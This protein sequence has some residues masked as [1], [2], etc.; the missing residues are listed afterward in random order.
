MTDAS[1]EEDRQAWGLKL[2]SG[3]SAVEFCEKR[4]VVGVGWHDVDL[5]L[6]RKGDISGTR[7][8][9]QSV[10]GEHYK[11]AW[12]GALHRFVC[13]CSIGDYVAYYVPQRKE[14]VVAGV[15]GEA[16]RREDELDT[17]IDI[18]IERQVEIFGTFPIVGFHAPLRGR[19]TIPRQAIWQLH[20][21]WP[22]LDALVRGE[23]PT[24]SAAPDPAVIEAMR[25]LRSLVT[26]RLRKLNS[27][28]YELLT[29]QY[30][31]AHGAEIIG[32]VG[33]RS[34]YD[35]HAVF[36]RGDLGTHWFAQVKRFE[37]K[38]V[39][40]GDLQT[41][42]DNAGDSGQLCYVSADG[43]TKEAWE[44]ADDASIYLL[45]SGDFVP[46]ALAGELGNVIQPKLELP[47]WGTLRDK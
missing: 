3:G 23:D 26:E 4:S 7:E 43:F 16:T 42:L 47:G 11:A 34:V 20:D 36:G 13:E 9:V 18:W 30:F 39:G 10:T 40:V 2:G 28:D 21:A 29:A 41:F 6:V 44:F 12:P 15:T 35:V 17:D 24:L 14:V 27:S 33:S 22:T 38:Q 1:F 46:L 45:E 32:K 8:H 37:G 31:K 5:E 25:R 19:V